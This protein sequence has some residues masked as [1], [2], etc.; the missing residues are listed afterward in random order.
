MKKGLKR[1]A[2]VALA[3]MLM[4]AAG[5]FG[6]ADYPEMEPVNTADMALASTED[7]SIRISYPAD[8]WTVQEGVSPL[9]LMYTETMDTD[10]VCNV[11]VQVSQE[12]TGDLTENDMQ[13][14]L[15]ATNEYVGYI[16]VDLAEL[17]QLNGQPVIYWECTI[18]F[19]EEIMDAAIEAGGLTEQEIE[20]Y[21]GR[22]ALLNIPP[23]HQIMMYAVADGCLFTYVGTYYDGAQKQSVLDALTVIIPNTEKV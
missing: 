6:K 12:F 20:A 23:T 7:G 11:N 1:A 21:G 15:D 13:K 3:L 10:S 2:A 19:T 18:Q 16:T 22:E 14:L 4:L 17:R 8:L 9:T 5:C